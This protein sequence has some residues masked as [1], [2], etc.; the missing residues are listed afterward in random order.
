[1]GSGNAGLRVG[2]TLEVRGAEGGVEATLPGITMDDQQASAFP[3][4]LP[5]RSRRS[6]LVSALF[7][8]Q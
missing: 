8:L 7:A 2:S 3:G 1:M 6:H 5:A 4:S